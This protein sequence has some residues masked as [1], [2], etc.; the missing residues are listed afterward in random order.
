MKQFAVTQVEALQC[1]C[2]NQE[3]GNLGVAVG[4]AEGS[5]WDWVVCSR[6]RC[7]LI[8]LVGEWVCECSVIRHRVR[9]AEYKTNLP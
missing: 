4:S 5:C 7:P 6:S 3:S 9:S 2:Q 8:F 1:S